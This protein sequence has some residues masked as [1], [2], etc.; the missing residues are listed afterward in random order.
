[1]DADPSKSTKPL[2]QTGRYPVSLL[3]SA[4]LAPVLTF[5]LTFPAV[6]VQLVPAHAVAVSRQAVLGVQTLVVAVAVVRGAVG[7]RLSCETAR[8]HTR[9]RPHFTH[10]DTQTETQKNLR[11]TSL[12]FDG[13]LLGPRSGANSWSLV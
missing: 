9:L 2:S 1:M 5:G 7:G 8:G 10:P 12:W 3:L 13:V 11:G 6:A 4:E